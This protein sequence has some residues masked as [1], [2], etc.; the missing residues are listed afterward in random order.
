MLSKRKTTFYPMLNTDINS[1]SFIDEERRRIILQ[2]IKFDVE[3]G[4]IYTILG[5]NGSGKSTLIKSLTNLLPA[6]QHEIKGKV[7][8]YETDLLH[9]SS[10]TLQ[11]IR[12][13]KIRY[14]FQDVANSLDPLKKLKYYF[15]LSEAKREQIEEQ[16]NFFLLPGYKKISDLHSYE[17]SGGMAQRLLIV[18]ALLANPDLII[19]DEPTSGVDYAVMNLILLKLKEFIKGKENSVLIVTQDINFARKSSDYIAYLSN[20][21]LTNFSPPDEFILSTNDDEMKN[22]IQSYKEISNASA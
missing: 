1:V 3:K 12:K 10:E 7:I 2:N 11:E 18:L 4:K 21:E 20:G 13:N 16:L 17:L 19:L 8:F 14:V 6:A 22:F 9:T 5:K 15:H